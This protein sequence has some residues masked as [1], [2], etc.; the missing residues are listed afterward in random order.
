[1][2][3]WL[4]S[5]LPVALVITGSCSGAEP[6]GADALEGASQL[7]GIPPSIAA[8][9]LQA[10]AKEPAV[11]DLY[12]DIGWVSLWSPRAEQAFVS[13]LEKR[14]AHGLDRLNF[15][16]DLRQLS[17]AEREIALTRAALNFAG[18]LGH[19]LVDPAKLHAIYTIERPEIDL[20]RGL[21][22]AVRNDRMVSWL[23]S[24]AP[25]TAEYRVLADAY[26]QQR[27]AASGEIS[28][29]VASGSL[30]RPGDRDPRIQQIVHALVDNS[31]LPIQP[32]PAASSRSQAGE[33][34]IYKPAI[35]MAVK[36]F[37]QDY[38]IR[39]DGVIGA[40]TLAFLNVQPGDRARSIAVAMERLRWLARDPPSTRIDVN[41]AAAELSY[42]RHGKLVD[43]RKVVV[44][45]PGTE[46]PQISTSLFR[47]VANPTWTVPKSIQRGEL[48]GKSAAYFRR[49]NM[50]WR[51]GWIVQGSGPRNSLGLVKFDMRNDFAI[52]LHDTP[53]K[54]LF[55]LQQRQLSHGCVRVSDA[56]GFSRML[57]E[58]Q[59]IAVRWSKAQ[60][61]RSMKFVELPTE[62]P[63]RLYYR[64]VYVDHANKLTYRT[65]P[66]G[67]NVAVAEA[68]GFGKDADNKFG[69]RVNAIWP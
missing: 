35:V 33:Q 59:G 11:R 55:D 40:D 30:I 56:L 14:S 54:K 16:P 38:G 44:G 60:A 9:A 37:Q 64:T 53:A 52:Y 45:K 66:Y 17:Q 26:K 41:V 36:E 57:A 68:L 8:S 29:Q 58:H 42:F 18:A 10:E 27:K 15:L 31:Y 62:I 43:H 24:L 1:V 2:K 7:S 3:F 20:G 19:G 12:A 67:W 47:L 5:I 23:D 48:A 28:G 4:V 49:N 51:N 32:Q 61:A 25:D 13:S 63:V 46:T 65:D 6:D 22:A 50:T 39:D 34:D 69:A 21:L